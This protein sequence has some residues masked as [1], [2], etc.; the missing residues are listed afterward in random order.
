MPVGADTF[1]EALRMGA[2]VFHALKK[3]LQGAR[4]NHRRR[5]RRRL[6]PEPDVQRGGAQGD[7][8]S[9]RARPATSPASRCR[10]ALDV[11]S[12]RAVPRT[13]STSAKAKGVSPTSAEEM[14]DFYDELVRQVPDRLHRRRLGRGRLGRLEEAHRSARR[15]GAAGGRRP[16]RHQHRAACAGHRERRRQHHPGQGEPDRHADRNARR[17]RDGQ[18][19]RLHRGHLP[20]LRRDRRHHHR[21]HRRG[22][23][24]P[25]RSRP[26]APRR[27]DRVAKY[28][29]LLRIEE[30]LERQRRL[31]GKTAFYNLKG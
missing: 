8:R 14:I 2:E 21:R 22:D 11:A 25:G 31:S 27:T 30:E 12:T 15:Q 29:Q 18:A 1:R 5:R 3:V 17:R 26:G 23:Q 20:P 16:V 6:C 13:A 19:G 10:S 7:P 4:A 9:D 24:L 28:N